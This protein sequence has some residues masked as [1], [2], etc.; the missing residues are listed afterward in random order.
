[1]TERVR[2]LL[3]ENEEDQRE[4]FTMALTRLGYDVVATQDGAAA[5]TE[6]WS[7]L[8]SSRPF[9]V[10][11]LDLA[12]PRM[13]GLTVARRI[14]EI[15]SKA[16][17]R[18]EMAREYGYPPPAD[19]PRA[20]IIG[21]TAHIDL[22]ADREMFEKVIDVMLEKPLDFEEIKRALATTIR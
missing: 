12:M 15:E 16:D 18:A 3:A 8:S 7:A 4:L 14:R 9:S 5:M 2:V 17:I 11:W 6:Y 22:Q 13:D 1:M 21:C 20:Y 10:I 19:I